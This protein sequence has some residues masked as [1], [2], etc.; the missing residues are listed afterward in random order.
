MSF[1]A[2]GALWMLGLGSVPII[3]HLLNRRRFRVVEWAPMRF[4]RQVAEL[5][6]RRLRLEEILLLLIRTAFILAVAFAVAR[7]AVSRESK[8]FNITFGARVSRILIIDDSLS[9]GYRVG[10]QSAFDRARAAAARLVEQIPD[11]DALAI[12]TT[13][14]PS[15]LR[16]SS[17][18][19]RDKSGALNVIK[20]VEITDAACSLTSVLDAARRHL[21]ASPFPAKEIV[22]IT[23]LR[24]QGWDHGV[25]EKA[26]EL[27]GDGAKLTI[28]D[29][30][31]DRFDD[32][33]IVNI[34]TAAPWTFPGVPTEI[35]ATLRNSG[36]SAAEP[37]GELRVGTSART[38]TLTKIEPGETAQSR[39]RITID[40]PGHAAVSLKLTN[41]ALPADDVRWVS[42]AV[43]EKVEVLLVDGEPSNVKF[44]GASDFARLALGIGAVPFRVTVMSENEWLS[45]AQP[46]ADLTVLCNVSPPPRD[47]ALELEKRVRA[48]MGILLFAGDH[49]DPAAANESLYRG[50]QGLLPFPVDAIR[51]DPAKGL[52]I[53]DAEDSPV[54]VLKQLSPA[55]LANITTRKRLQLGKPAAP[56]ARARV[57]A[58]WDGEEAG[59]AIV[60]RTFGFGRVLLWTTGA[61]R[62]WSDWPIDP[63]WLLMFR[64]ACLRCARAPVESLT[65]EAGPSLKLQFAKGIMA[66]ARL[67]RSGESQSAAVE[68][69]DVENATELNAGSVFR[70]GQYEVSWRDAGGARASRPL[71]VNPAVAEMRLDRIDEPALRELLRPLPVQVFTDQQFGSDAAASTREL[72]HMLIALGAF[73]FMFECAFMV[74]HG[75]DGS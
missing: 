75:R 37:S 8:F 74:W 59:A 46:D 52:T 4:L 34:E 42:V 1:F 40:S 16:F 47:R 22:M 72:W 5:H 63:T 25:P 44:D 13:A 14:D 20:S 64:D 3:I 53:A 19:L 67:S 33:A 23:D 10:I 36:A 38:V 31:A 12:M 2:A 39:F 54:I 32:V 35:V 11:D 6:R 43:R 30:G 66:D 26:V 56:D 29:T 24:R 15:R 58:T 41:D 73:L 55:A 27:A 51:E 50:G 17:A 62:T 60:D 57:L 18:P 71:A 28:I 70:A 48:G 9:M 61:D 49:F 68:A 21:A 45:Q 69:R 65:S 7:P